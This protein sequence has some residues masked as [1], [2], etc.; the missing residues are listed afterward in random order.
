MASG[1][2]SQ[3]PYPFVSLSYVWGLWWPETIIPGVK[4]HWSLK[5]IK[6]SLK[7]LKYSEN[8]CYTEKQNQKMLLE[9]NESNRFAQ[10]RFATNLQF[11]KKKNAIS[12]KSNKV[13]FNRM[14]SAYTNFF[15]LSSFHSKTAFPEF[16]SHLFF[17]FWTFSVV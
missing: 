9:K 12:A 2:S 5:Q 4:D 16:C 15:A 8:Y 11:L 7:N 3:N 13:K 10:W 1:W 17:S 6:W 14:R